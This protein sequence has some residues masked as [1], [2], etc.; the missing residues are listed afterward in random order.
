MFPSK[1]TFKNIDRQQKIKEALYLVYLLQ[2]TKEI[3]MALA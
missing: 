3:S 2:K 1:R